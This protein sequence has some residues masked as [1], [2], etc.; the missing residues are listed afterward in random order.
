MCV[1]HGGGK[2]SVGTR[3]GRAGDSLGVR[4]GGETGVQRELRAFVSCRERCVVCTR[5]KG[6]FASPSISV[7]RTYRFF[8]FGFVK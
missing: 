8:F 1:L 2:F 6:Q 5:R 7:A 3:A 4:A